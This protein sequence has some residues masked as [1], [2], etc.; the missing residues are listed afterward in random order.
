MKTVNIVTSN[1]FPE[2][3]GGANR[4]M[5][6]AKTLEAYN[7]RVR[8]I[9][10]GEKEEIVEISSGIMVHYVARNAFTQGSFFKRAI[11]EM[12]YAYKLVQKN[13]GL[14]SDFTITTVPYMFLLP[15]QV[16]FDF[17][18]HYILDIRDLAWEYLPDQGFKGKMK[19]VISAVMYAS[20]K[21]YKNISVTNQ[22]EKNVIQNHVPESR[23][24][25]IYNGIDQQKFE[26]LK[27]LEFKPLDHFTLT[28]IGNIGLAQNIRT[29]IDTAVVLK[30]TNV[31][32]NI[33]G[34]GKER[35]HLERYVS[36]N[37]IQN[38]F[39]LGEKKW[40]EL[41]DV[42]AQSSVLYAQLTKDYDSAV[43]S[44]LYEYAST[45]LPII[46]GGVGES[47]VFME[48]LSGTICVEP[49]DIEALAHSILQMQENPRKKI[50]EN[51]TL[52]EN[53]FIRD[54]VN[55]KFLKFFSD[56][57]GIEKREGVK[58]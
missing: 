13:R 36:E 46:Y 7:Y 27:A 16:L 34:G 32:F 10:L 9:S 51:Q 21:R 11:H 22:Y 17:K 6:I 37:G 55:L 14:D 2:I 57:F 28:Y 47:K 20:M 31:V 29:L 33:V 39:F 50:T 25:V 24:E 18:S 53:N 26:V 56:D 38:V 41:M 43:P 1:F 8:V 58:R 19:K 3:S 35:E 54:V 15:T 42:Y 49:D 45:G 12:Y 52:I 30:D 5:S 44:K 40:D 48:R 4:V 23:I